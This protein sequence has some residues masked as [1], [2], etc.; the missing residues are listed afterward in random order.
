ML[1]AVGLTWD[2]QGTVS[3]Y[4]TPP[5]PSPCPR[6]KTIEQDHSVGPGRPVPKMKDEIK[7]WCLKNRA[8]FHCRQKNAGHSAQN[9]PR[10]QAMSG[11]GLGAVNED[12]IDQPENG[13]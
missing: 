1:A 7:G 9:C 4:G 6:L 12:F 2:G 10:F 3:G 11:R 5:P 8:C 13:K